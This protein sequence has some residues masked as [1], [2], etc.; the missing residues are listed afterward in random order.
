MLEQ[1]LEEL[2]VAETKEKFPNVAYEIVRPRQRKYKELYTAYQMWVELNKFKTRVTNRIGAVERG[3]SHID[4]GMSALFLEGGTEIKRER[5]TPSGR[6]KVKV[7][8]AGSGIA[9]LQDLA[10]DEMHSYGW[11]HP[12]WDWL[13]SISG[14]AGN[15]AAK[16]LALV[17]DIERFPTIASLWRYSG[18]GIF[19][20]W[21]D[22]DGK[23]MAPEQG[24]K[25]SRQKVDGEEVTVRWFERAEPKPEWKLVRIADPQKSRRPKGWNAP[26]NTV[27]KSH[28]YVINEGMIRAQNSKYVDL[29]YPAKEK[30]IA[31]GKTKMQGH[32]SAFRIMSKELLKDFWLEFRTREGLPI[33]DKWA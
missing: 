18:Y 9:G 1:E 25:S 10:V 21:L 24:Y 29:Y 4:A 6:E 28:L 13:T 20:Y 2:D 5:R 19:R 7:Y 31:Q 11:Y 3:D 8:N 32:L 33:S 17:D 12:M 27:L 23:V 15:N 16:L 30:Y 22:A 26:D 14:I